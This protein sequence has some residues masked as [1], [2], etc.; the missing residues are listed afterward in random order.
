MPKVLLVL[1]IAVLLNAFTVK[2]QEYTAASIKQTIQDFKK[3]P[4]GPYLRIRWFCEDG[5]MREPKDPCPEGVDG[6]QHASYK[7]LTENLAE[8]NHLFFGEILAAADKNK[9]WD[10]AQEQ[11]RL[12]QYQLNKYLQSVDNG[13]ILD[14]AQFYR[15]AIQSEDEEAW[16]IEFYEWLLKDDAR[17]EKNYYVIRQ[18]LKDIPHS[19]DDN[20]AQRMRSES[21]VIAEEFPKFMDV[22]VKIHGQPEVSDLALVQNFRQEYSD[23]LTPEL[24]EQFDALV[25]TLN[26]Y[27]API[28]LERLK[29]QVASIKGDFDVKQLSLIHI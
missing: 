7:P 6:I 5:T 24:K 3:D 14:K 9:F 16:G 10:A 1:F 26:E 23:E 20:I 25:A 15:G 12:K 4:R 29:N 2:A 17:L 21:K 8:R 27:Y 18:S 22:R 19:G 13:W 11:S 28:N